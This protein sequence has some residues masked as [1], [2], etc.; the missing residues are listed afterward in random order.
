M[1]APATLPAFDVPPLNPDELPFEFSGSGGAY[2]KIWIV[3]LLLSIVTLGLY[4]PW[5]KVRRERYFMGNTLL[6]GSAF[7]YHADPVKIL[8]GRLLVMAAIVVLNIAAEFN[9]LFN[10]VVM[11]LF[12]V[13]LPWMISRALRFRAHNTSWRGLRFAFDGL[14][15][16][17]AK[18]WVLWPIAGVL[19]AGIL[20][21]FALANQRRYLFNH[22]RFGQAA[23]DIDLPVGPV[24]R[25]FGRVALLA[26]VYVAV[27]VALGFVLGG[28]LDLFA[29]GAMGQG[30]G[31]EVFGLYLMLAMLALYVGFALIAPY[32]SACMANLSFNRANLQNHG[33]FS[34]M[35]AGRYVFIVLTNWLL[36]ALTLGLYRPFA[37]VRLWRYRVEHLAL[38][39]AGTL[40]AFM[41]VQAEEARVIG[42]EAA[43][44]LDVDLGF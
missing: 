28:P 13:L 33:F 11:V 39:P 3:N 32:V 15:W 6:D 34:D 42:E 8:K 20:F 26:L 40:T 10:L 27:L 37:V 4:S 16:E 36:T 5:A 29:S 23:F 17:A 21:P 35:V 18:A 14:T 38:L 9:P 25:V 7:D 24:Y 1:N 31:R 12:A 30:G 44:L 2:F 22:L 41:A 19:S 43:D